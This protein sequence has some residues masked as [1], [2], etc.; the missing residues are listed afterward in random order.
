[1][2]QPNTSR[3]KRVASGVLMAGAV[4]TALTT[5]GLPAWAASQKAPADTAQKKLTETVTMSGGW[6]SPEMARLAESSGRLLLHRIDA[7]A[8][9]IKTGDYKYAHRELDG[10][11]D[12]A[13]AI[14]TMMPFL[15]VVD[16]IKGAKNKLVAE[17]TEFLRDDLLPIYGQ[18]DEMALF[19][20]EVAQKARQQVTNAE[21]KADAGKK[22]EAA[23][24]LDSA[25]ET[26][27]STTVYMPVDYV[28]GQV[29]AARRALYSPE[30]DSL[31]AQRAL[32]NARK[33]LI[34]V[35]TTVEEEP[36][37]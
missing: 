10:A 12:T 31:S 9:M 17:G 28:Y 19:A 34:A 14:K 5:A 27:T 6:A 29:A 22:S 33:S 1:M 11:L 23:K 24:T 15:V 16:Q 21:E 18:L 3:T 32:D 7:A 36:Q 37:S 2:R 35:V 4:A 20:P 26:I 25:I 13:G 30:P 8:D